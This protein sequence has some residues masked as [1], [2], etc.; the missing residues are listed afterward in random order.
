MREKIRL[1][2]LNSGNNIV[3]TKQISPYNLTDLQVDGGVEGSAGLPQPE[4]LVVLPPHL[5][6]APACVAWLLPAIIVAVR[7]QVEAPEIVGSHSSS[8]CQHP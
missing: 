3:H 4:Q 2:E 8:L 7:K 6:G 1:R 5:L